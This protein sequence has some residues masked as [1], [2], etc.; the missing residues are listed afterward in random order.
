[1]TGFGQAETETE[2]LS[3]KVECKS[4]NGKFLELN[5]RLPRQWQHKELE[6]RNECSKRIERGTATVAVTITYKNAEDKVLAVNRDVAAYYLNELKDIAQHQQLKTEQLFHSVFD[7]PNIVQPKEEENNDED[8]KLI[9][10]TA[11]K[12]LEDFNTYRRTEGLALEKELLLLNEQIKTKTNELGS[13]EEERIKRLRQKLATELE[14]LKN[15]LVDKNRFEQELIYYIEKLDISEEKQRLLQHCEY[16][17][18]TLNLAS[19]GKKLGFIA[20]EMGREINTIGSKSN[21]ANMQ[22]KVVEMKDELEK[23]KEQINNVL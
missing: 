16:F 4:L 22:R 20:Q 18:Q 7:F 11:H 10:Q 13:F 9:V 2:K 8:W 12:A 1:M 14:T 19:S 3:C 5:M 21:E 6:L 23:I 15:D 17:E